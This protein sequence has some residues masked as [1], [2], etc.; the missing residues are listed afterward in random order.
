M[1]L[2]ST[3]Q[4]TLQLFLQYR[5]KLRQL[6]SNHKVDDRNRFSFMNDPV[7]LYLTE[8][9]FY[10]KDKYKLD[11]SKK[12]YRI[13]PDVKFNDNVEYLKY[14]YTNYLKSNEYEL[15]PIYTLFIKLVQEFFDSLY[16][17]AKEYFNRSVDSKN[18]SIRPFEFFNN[19]NRNIV[20]LKKLSVL[21]EV[22]LQENP[23]LIKQANDTTALR[24]K[25]ID[26]YGNIERKITIRL[27]GIDFTVELSNDNSKNRNTSALNV[28][29]QRNR[30]FSNVQVQGF[31]LNKFIDTLHLCISKHAG[32]PTSRENDKYK[33]LLKK[34]LG[35]DIFTGYELNFEG[36]TINKVF[37]LVEFDRLYKEFNSIEK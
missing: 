37:T 14:N 3:N 28:E 5:E 34:D 22:L 36:L 18:S 26:N 1:K 32:Y 31:E 10:S 25:W 8:V 15:D 4:T 21:I 30:H 13:V 6:L 2:N 19:I 12:D 7:F 35:E 24:C 17:L 20:R 11:K 9:H 23:S 29:S 27:D 16:E 33:I